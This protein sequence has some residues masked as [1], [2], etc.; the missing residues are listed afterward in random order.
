MSRSL[1]LFSLLAACGGSEPSPVEQ[2]DDL[3]D[4][5]CDR[6]VQCV[7]GAGGMHTTCVQ[8]LQQVISCG[9]VKAVSAT[10]DRCMDQLAAYSC[11]VLFPIDPQTGDPMLELPADCMGVV[12]SRELGP[13]V[14]L[15]ELATKEPWE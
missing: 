12:L 1:V 7:A 10:Y 6:A 14:S 3:V 9:S 11:P 8:E 2:C 4:L 5:I 13:E 15:P